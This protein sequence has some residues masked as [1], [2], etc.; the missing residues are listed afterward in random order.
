MR[1]FITDEVAQALGLSFTPQ[2]DFVDLYYDGEYRGTYQLSEK[3]EVNGGRFDIAELENES[4]DEVDI[5]SHPAAMG[6]NS[7][8]NAFKY[9]TGVKQ[10]ADIT[11]GYLVELDQAYYAA[12]RSWFTVQHCDDL[13]HFVLKSPEDASEDEVRYISER[14]Q[15][16]FDHQNLSSVASYIDVDQLARVFLVEELAKN[17]D[18]IKYSS[19]YFYVDANDALLHAGPVW[20]FDNAYGIHTQT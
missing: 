13:L 17:P 6:Q 12:E 11:G 16:A 3:V 20:D 7:Y 8:G 5:E 9:V 2:S 18:Y 1:N 4:E 14:F 15:D 19:T 10:P